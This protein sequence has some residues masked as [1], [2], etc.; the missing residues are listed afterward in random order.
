M[1]VV[2]SATSILLK[3]RDGFSQLA[4][5]V[6]KLGLLTNGGSFRGK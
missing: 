6:R 4:P 3:A 5:S 2:E 1:G